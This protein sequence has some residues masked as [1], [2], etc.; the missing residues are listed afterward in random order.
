MPKNPGF[1]N[2]FLLYKNRSH[3]KK[4]KIGFV[5]RVDIDP[6]SRLWDKQAILREKQ[7]EKLK[8]PLFGT[9]KRTFL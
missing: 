7:K 4:I 5:F 6:S 9:K 3:E 1:V 2:L 8:L